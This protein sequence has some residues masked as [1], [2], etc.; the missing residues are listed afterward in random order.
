MGFKVYLVLNG[1][2]ARGWGHILRHPERARWAEHDHVRGCSCG[3]RN[4]GCLLAVVFDDDHWRFDAA[5]L[6][7][8]VS[9][10]KI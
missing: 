1:I 3:L 4:G 10:S 9:S 7:R 2:V 8:A 6:S 5:E